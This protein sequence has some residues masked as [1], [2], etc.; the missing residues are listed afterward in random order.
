V[1]CGRI[2]FMK[3]PGKRAGLSTLFKYAGVPRVVSLI[4][5]VIALILYVLGIYHLT[6]PNQ[7]W[8]SGTTEIVAATLLLIAGYRVSRVIAMIIVLVVAVVLSVIGIRHLIHGGGWRSGIVEVFF[9]ALLIVS[10]WIIHRDQG[11]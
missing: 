6:Q 9:T 1:V 4:D 8:R 7:A 11:R 3:V 5:T 2:S 10:A